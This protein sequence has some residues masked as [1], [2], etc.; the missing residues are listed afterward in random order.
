[1]IV[2]QQG[3]HRTPRGELPGEPVLLPTGRPPIGHLRDLSAAQLGERLVTRRLG[4]GRPPA[5][6]GREELLGGEGAQLDQPKARAVEQVYSTPAAQ[7]GQL[8]LQSGGK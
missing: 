4:R 1:M 8:F 3:G 7:L 2:A 6:G 5:D